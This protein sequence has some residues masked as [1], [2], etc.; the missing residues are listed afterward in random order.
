MSQGIV[1]CTELTEKEGRKAGLYRSTFGSSHGV[2]IADAL[3]AATAH[4]HG[5]TLCTRNLKHYPMR[6]LKKLRV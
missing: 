3:I 2:E 1:R 6:D 4:T 5:F